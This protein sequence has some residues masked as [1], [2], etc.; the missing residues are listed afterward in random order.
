MNYTKQDIDWMK[1]TKRL[2]LSKLETLDHYFVVLFLSFIPLITLYDLLK[3]YLG[4][5]DG[6]RS[7]TELATA[8][9]PFLILALIAFINQRKRLQFRVVRIKYTDDD[10]REAAK[11]TS[12]NLQ[13]RVETDRQDVFR[14]FRGWNWTSSW[15]EMITIL[16]EENMLLLNSISDP[17][18][19]PT[20]S[21]FGWDK[22][23]IN[24]FLLNLAQTLQ[25]ISSSTWFEDEEAK[26]WYAK[27]YMYYIGYLCSIC[28]ILFAMFLVSEGKVGMAVTLLGLA[29]FY[30]YSDLNLNTH[31]TNAKKD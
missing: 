12:E 14:A 13:W 31:Q 22:K 15:G 16:R 29:A 19:K 7:A 18:Q 8:Q 21:S 25:G 11:R 3:M 10:F 1:R 6:V 24:V 28:L 20:F 2:K 27:S 4:T 30:L 23:N 26:K 9:L 17:S 5:Y